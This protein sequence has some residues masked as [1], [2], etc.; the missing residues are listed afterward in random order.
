MGKNTLKDCAALGVKLLVWSITQE[1]MSEKISI[2]K[3]DVANTFYIREI[4]RAG[5]LPPGN[6]DTENV[7]YQAATVIRQ[8]WLHTCV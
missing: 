1:A 5:K 2:N 3:L 8:L 7:I 4:L 6:R